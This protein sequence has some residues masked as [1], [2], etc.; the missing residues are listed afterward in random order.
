M[1]KAVFIVSA[2]KRDDVKEE[3]QGN[4]PAAEFAG[5]PRLDIGCS[6]RV[7]VSHDHRYIRDTVG[8]IGSA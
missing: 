8:I 1:A 6:V 2:A 5:R 3:K 7:S 4:E